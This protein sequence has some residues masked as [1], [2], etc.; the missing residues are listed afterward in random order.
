ME[1]MYT[2]GL[3]ELYGVLVLRKSVFLKQGSSDYKFQMFVVSVLNYCYFIYRLAVFPDIH[4]S[5]KY[6][7]IKMFHLKSIAGMMTKYLF[8][9]K[10]G[11]NQW[12][13]SYLISAI[14][15]LHFQ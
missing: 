9:F 3:E 12:K 15:D 11:A 1:R 10:M 6:S 13:Q 4:N 7:Y 5:R 8:V 2:H 14:N